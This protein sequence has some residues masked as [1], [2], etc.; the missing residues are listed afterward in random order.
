VSR[1]SHREIDAGQNGEHIGLQACDQQ[2]ARSAQ[3]REV[4]GRVAPSQPRYPNAPIMLTKLATSL[5]VM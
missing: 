1:G 4:S 2:S 3:T 5:S